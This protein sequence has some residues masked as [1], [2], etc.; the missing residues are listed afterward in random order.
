MS[1][2]WYRHGAKVVFLGWEPGDRGYYVN[3]VDLCVDCGG[4]GEI[5]GSDE[6]CPG[7]GGEG[8][9]LEKLNPSE[10]KSGLTMDQ[11]SDALEDQAIALPYFVK[12][13]LEEDQ[14][15]NAGPTVIH[16]YDLDSEV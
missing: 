5:E 2:R 3:I 14:R 1:R 4:T 8:I 7:C 15:I 13:D 6:V 11:V 16:E 9:Q 12:A 10:R